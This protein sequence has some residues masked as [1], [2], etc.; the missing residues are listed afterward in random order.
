M[1]KRSCMG[2]MLAAA[3]VAACGF[4]ITKQNNVQLGVDG[5]TPCLTI[6]TGGSENKVFL[7]QDEETGYFFLP[8]CVKNHKVRLEDG[9]ENSVRIDGELLKPGETFVWEEN[10]EIGR[11]HV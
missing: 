10:T 7:W 11:A 1:R 6:R 9:G 3:V 4:Y 2:L 5:D 8:S